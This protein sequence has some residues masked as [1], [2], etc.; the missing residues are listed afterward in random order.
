MQIK[1]QAGLEVID[2]DFCE[3]VQQQ[4]Q[5][6]L[7]RCYQCYT[8]ALGCP[9]AF[10]TDYT[11]NQIIRMVQ[12]GLR[13]KV[14]QSGLI[15][16][17]ASCETC[18][19]RCP[20]EVDIVKLMDTLRSMSLQEQPAKRVKDVIHMHKTFLKNVEKRG[21]I[22]ELGF[23]IGMKMGSVET[24]KPS[25]QLLED[26]LLGYK[27]FSRGKLKLLPHRIQGVNHIKEIYRKVQE[28]KNQYNQ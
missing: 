12:A 3:Q 26:A 14:L 1:S 17:C 21:R 8:C 4:S 22:H 24:L 23:I 27:M 11:P 2:L 6:H 20:N 15:W 28:K 18:V 5:S 7:E 9:V 16:L 13:E 19:A 10:A 25:V